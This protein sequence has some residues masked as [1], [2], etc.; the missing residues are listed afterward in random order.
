MTPQ[1][2]V[3]IANPGE[4][5]IPVRIVTQGPSDP[6]EIVTGGPSDPVRIVTGGPSDPVR[7]TF[8]P[9]PPVAYPP[10]L[11]SAEVGNAGASLVTLL[12]DEPLA[13]S[14]GARKDGWSVEVNGG[15]YGVIQGLLMNPQLIYIGL[16][17]P[18]MH[19][20]IVNVFYDKS[21]GHIIDVDDGLQLE[22]FVHS[23]D[24]N[25]P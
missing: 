21:S 17:I 2:R 9:P 8:A 12:F 4:P 23:V 19:G 13:L 16:A 25:L 22:S 7:G 11:T 18:V 24:N 6:V 10:S 5:S 14:S 3:R 15:W 20:D 1:K